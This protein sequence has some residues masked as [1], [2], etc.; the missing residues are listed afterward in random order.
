MYG[1][2]L[3]HGIGTS[4]NPEKGCM[5]F[6][7]CVQEPIALLHLGVHLNQEKYIKEACN[8][9]A[10][11]SNKSLVYQWM[12]SIFKQGTKIPENPE[13]A[14]I[15]FGYSLKIAKEKFEDIEPLRS[16]ISRLPQLGNE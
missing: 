12:G 1:L 11:D 15:W 9:L 6:S 5:F 8:I 7:K 2:M 10:L 4:P 14:L 3:F 13:L 16:K